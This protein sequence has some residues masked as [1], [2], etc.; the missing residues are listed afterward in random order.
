VKAEK[1]EKQ[2][3]VVGEIV[4]KLK[5]SDL[6]VLVNYRGLT[7]EQL[8]ELRG[9]LHQE[10]SKVK[11]YKNTLTRRAVDEM[12]LVC[13]TG[14]FKEPTA[15]V[16]SEK[17]P[18]SVAKIV[19]DFAADNELF[20]IKGGFFE[21]KTIDLVTLDSLAKLPSR[22]VLIAKAVGAIK[23]PLTGLV[24]TLSGP[25]R[26]LVYTLKAISDKKSGGE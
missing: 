1:R 5:E 20:Q 13:P 7:V 9:K 23:S 8:S 3:S 21:D 19:V 16:T 22:E 25:V 6:S 10:G 2:Q 11:V 18:V 4:G 14:F 15:L 17:D 26:G 12:K 24:M